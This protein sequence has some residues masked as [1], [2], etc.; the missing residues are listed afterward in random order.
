VLVHG[1][2]GTAAHF[3]PVIEELSLHHRVIAIDLY[4]MGFSERSADFR[5]GWDLWADQIAD[6]LDALDI[7]RA[8]VLG[9]SLGG[10]VAITFADRHPERTGR[11]ILA[12]SAYSMPGYVFAMLTPGI[13]EWYLARKDFIGT[14]YDD[15]HRSELEAAYRVRGTRKALLRYT[16][17]MAL[18]VREFSQAVDRVAVPV[19]QI[20]GSQDREVSIR[21][22]R[23]FRDRLH[24]TRLVIVNGAGH[25]LMRDAPH[26]FVEAIEAF[27]CDRVGFVG[28]Q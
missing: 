16:R 22:A 17:R 26:E 12:G 2:G 5:Y 20:H 11:V 24:D 15:E 18:D 25:Y 4:G 21:A 28:S 6:V 10:T 13:G 27:L 1:L 14:S 8:H 23:R 3:A 9:H 7:E 19:L